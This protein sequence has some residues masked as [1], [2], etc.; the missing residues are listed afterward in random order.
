MC[1]CVGGWEERAGGC[2]SFHT[3]CTLQLMT[4]LLLPVR[5]WLCCHC[6][7]VDGVAATAVPLL[8][9]SCSCLDR[10]EA[11]SSQP[12]SVICVP[13]LNQWWSTSRFD[14]IA[15]FDPRAP[16]NVSPYVADPNQLNQFAVELLHSPP[17]AGLVLAATKGRQLVAWQYNPTAA[18]RW[19]GW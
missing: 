8:C 18:H 2:L 10:F 17:A 11:L 9:S 4:L 12:I 13:Q 5:S 19:G 7:S 3:C 14:R 15:A 6:C 16:A 1:V